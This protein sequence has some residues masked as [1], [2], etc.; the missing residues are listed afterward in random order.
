MAPGPRATRLRDEIFIANYGW[1]KVAALRFMLKCRVPLADL[2]QAASLGM[3]RAIDSYKLDGKAS[4]TNWASHWMR[5]EMQMLLLK[6][7]PTTEPIGGKNAKRRQAA[8]AGASAAELGVS[9]ETHARWTTPIHESS[10]EESDYD[11]TGDDA[12]GPRFGLSRFSRVILDMQGEAPDAIAD[13]GRTL[14][15]V[16]I[17]C[18]ALTLK[19]RD[20]I[21]RYIEDDAPSSVADIALEALRRAL[22]P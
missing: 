3:V 1:V 5:L 2:E 13:R 9:E 6:W 15:R 17:A 18:E 16:M 14:E 4:L 7:D 12:T 19:Q 11:S 22:T 8:K 21:A 20:A 10:Y